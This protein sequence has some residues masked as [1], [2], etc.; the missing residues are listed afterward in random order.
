[1]PGF[2]R[3]VLL[4]HIGMA[5]GVQAVVG[6]QS[7]K[8]HPPGLG[9]RPGA[10]VGEEFLPGLGVA[11]M[12][13]L[14]GGGFYQGVIV[15]EKIRSMEPHVVKTAETLNAP[16]GFRVHPGKQLLSEPVVGVICGHESHLIC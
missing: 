5:H 13:Q 8:V 14:S 2:S 15:K 16:G 6:K 7:V 10:G 1:M 4:F 12:S 9:I 3:G 11:G